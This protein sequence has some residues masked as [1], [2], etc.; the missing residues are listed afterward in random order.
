[1]L[2]AAGLIISQRQGK[3][4]LHCLTTLGESLLNRDA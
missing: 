4:V 3:S 1:V 2:R